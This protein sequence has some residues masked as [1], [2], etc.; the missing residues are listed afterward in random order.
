MGLERGVNPAGVGV[1][2]YDENVLYKILKEIIILNK[3][4]Y[5]A[6]PGGTCL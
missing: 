4:T 5:K 1:C 3:L 2:E 6:G